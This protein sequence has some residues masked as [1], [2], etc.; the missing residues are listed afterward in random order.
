MAKYDT[1]VTTLGELLE[2]PAVVEII[3]RHAPGLATNPMIGMAKGMPA[4]QA[5][6]MACGMI[7]KD[8]ADAIRADV[9]AL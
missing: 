4:S 6:S 5:L 7:G 3:D 9:E 8:S 1:N 2:D